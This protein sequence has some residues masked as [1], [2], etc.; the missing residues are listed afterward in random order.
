[1]SVTTQWQQDDLHLH[2]GYHTVRGVDLVVV[3]G[4]G[5]GGVLGRLDMIVFPKL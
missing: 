2:A 1:M 5:G 3:V 4:G